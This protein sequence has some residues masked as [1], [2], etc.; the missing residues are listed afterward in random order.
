MTS[1]KGAIIWRAY[2]TLL[3]GEDDNEMSTDRYFMCA[4]I[5]Q[6]APVRRSVRIKQESD[7]WLWNSW[8]WLY[9]GVFN[10][11]SDAILQFIVTLL[12]EIFISMK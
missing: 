12:Q 11:L 10:F 6:N 3:A 8:F 5:Y 1:S 9:N 4:F 7:K 2:E